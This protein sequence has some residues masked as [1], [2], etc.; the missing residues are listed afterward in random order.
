MQLRS[1]HI[2][3]GVTMLCGIV[4][5]AWAHSA[6]ADWTYIYCDGFD[7]NVAAADSVSHSVFWPEQA[8]PPSE[9]YLLFSSNHG[10]PPR[11]LLFMGYDGTPAILEYRLPMDTDNV[12]SNRRIGGFTEFD[13]QLLPSPTLDSKMSYCTSPDGQDWTEPVEVASGHHR[14]WTSSPDGTAHL[15]FQGNHAV[16]DNLCMRLWLG[17]VFHVDNKRELDVNNNGLSEVEPLAHV[18]AA[19]DA[20]QNGDR[21]FVWPGTYREGIDFRGKALLVRS[22]RDPAMIQAPNDYAVTF[23]SDEGPGSVLRNFVICN[24]HTGIFVVGAS[25]TLSHL[26]ITDNEHYAIAASFGADPHTS[27]C[28]FWNNS[29]GD[30][31]DCQ[32]QYS[33]LQDT[34]VGTAGNITGDPLFADPNQGDYHL[35]SQ[36][37]RFVPPD[38]NETGQF[39]TGAWVT[40]PITSP[41]IDTGNPN[42]YPMTERMP[43]GGRINMGAYGGT[44]WASLSTNEWLNK[45]DMNYDGIVNLLDFALAE[46]EGIDRCSAV[47]RI[48]LW[49][50]PWYESYTATDDLVMP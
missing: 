2:S 6:D 14:I 30:L 45:G 8:F 7:T 18:Q 34:V 39:Q 3:L 11:G 25:P 42:A 26:T 41:C 46:R 20:A 50:A 4:S 27:N 22:I 43:N 12:P 17:V 48:W 28:I 19:I 35:K 13:V 38:A 33:C 37:G 49:Q 15:R 31:L 36:R 32:A 29:S 5:W 16:L 21:V 10:V 23:Y 9:P 40:D 47:L 24:S 1:S 44:A